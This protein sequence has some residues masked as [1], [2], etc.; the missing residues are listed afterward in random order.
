MAFNGKEGKPISL[1][2]AKRW[3]KR[4]QDEN[5][6]DVKAY[7]FGCDNIRRLLDETDGDGDCK[8]IRI[9]FAIDDDGKMR[10]ILTGAT[11][12]QNNIL[13]KDDGKGGGGT[14]LDEGASCPPYC[15]TDP[16]DPLK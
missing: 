5:P 1:G 16:D 12:N 6:D 8:G 2:Q 14:I 3:T 15:P 4:Y 10:L 9:Y 13:P 7:F 11:E